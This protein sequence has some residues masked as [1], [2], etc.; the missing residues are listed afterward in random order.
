MFVLLQLRSLRETLRAYEPDASQARP[1]SSLEHIPVI[2]SIARG[3]QSTAELL[4]ARLY[5]YALS[6]RTRPPIDDTAVKCGMAV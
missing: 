1:A 4:N 5:G 3:D 6:I 2:G